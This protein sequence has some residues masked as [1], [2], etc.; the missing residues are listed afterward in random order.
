MQHV[1][2]AVSSKDAAALFA[3]GALFSHPSVVTDPEYGYA[4]QVAA[5]ESGYD[6]SNANPEI[7]LGCVG[8]FSCVDD[9]TWQDKMQ[10]DFGHSKYAEIY[11]VA[12]DIQYKVRTED[13]DGLQQYLK[14]K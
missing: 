10:R 14:I 9:L 11:S 3:V 8:N 4:W 2:T 12:L 7:G 1:H 5:C 6:C 13:W